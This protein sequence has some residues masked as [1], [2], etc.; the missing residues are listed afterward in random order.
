MSRVISLQSAERPLVSTRQRDFC[1]DLIG[2][3]LARVTITALIL[4]K[5]VAELSP[6]DMNA[7]H[8]TINSCIKELG[9]NIVDARHGLSPAIADAVRAVASRH[10]IRVRIA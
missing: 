3:G 10:R 8:R 1:K 6:A 4:G 9:Y 2:L 7:G 5:N